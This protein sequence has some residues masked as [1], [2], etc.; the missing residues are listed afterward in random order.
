M[1]DSI[2]LILFQRT[3]T[4]VETNWYIEFSHSSFVDFNSLAM[5]F[6]TNFKLP[7][8]YETDT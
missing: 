2:C 1:D 5:S 6:L 4:G 3:L 8:R 7:I